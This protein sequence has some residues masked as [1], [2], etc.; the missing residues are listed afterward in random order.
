M[1]VAASMVCACRMAAIGTFAAG[2]D[3]LGGGGGGLEDAAGG[4]GAFD[5][6]N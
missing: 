1:T 5:C 6:K 2:A 4:D 3:G